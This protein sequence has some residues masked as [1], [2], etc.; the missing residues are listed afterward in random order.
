MDKQFSVE[1]F[2]EGDL[3]ELYEA[4]L[5]QFERAGNLSLSEMNRAL[6]QTGLLLHM[7]MMTSLGIV[8][9]EAEV[10]RLDA[11]AERIGSDN[12]LWGV[13]ELARRQWRAGGG[14]F[15]VEA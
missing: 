15:D 2:L 8:R 6:L 3:A 14:A 9:D 1:T 5:Q 7:T 12:L 10:E 4:V 11:L 13:V